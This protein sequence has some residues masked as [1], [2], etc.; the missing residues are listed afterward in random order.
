MYSL[1]QRLNVVT[2]TA[3][4]GFLI[5]LPLAMLSGWLALPSVA[6][7]ADI[8]VNNIQVYH[9]SLDTSYSDGGVPR[10][11]VFTEIDM[12]ADLTSLFNWN[13]KQL[14]VNLVA[15][16]ESKSYEKNQIAVWDTLVLSVEE[17]KLKLRGMSH[18][19]G[20]DNIRRTFD[21]VTFSL[22]WNIVPWVGFMLNGRQSGEG[23]KFVLPP[24]KKAN[25]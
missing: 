9:G 20:L 12:D 21:S 1:L 24:A 13:T 19:Y 14:Y 17:A 7:S 15:E 8:A 16:Y 10:D 25:R 6:P 22:H 3:T 5:L 18:K 23:T 11:F 2:A 4:T